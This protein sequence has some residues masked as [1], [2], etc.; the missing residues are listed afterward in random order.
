MG[1]KGAHRGRLT[2]ATQ[3]AG[4]KIVGS[5]RPRW[6]LCFADVYGLTREESTYREATLGFIGWLVV[7]NVTP[8]WKGS[9]GG[10]TY[11]WVGDVKSAR[12]WS[13]GVTASRAGWA[14]PWMDGVL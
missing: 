10:F 5:A 3:R 4:F 6:V 8:S 2:A 12:K 11:S 7:L 1:V 14:I 13:L 9:K